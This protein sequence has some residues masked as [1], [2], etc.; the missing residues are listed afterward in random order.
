MDERQCLLLEQVKAM[1][2]EMQAN[3][4]R[5]GAEFDAI[6]KDMLQESGHHQPWIEKALGPRTRPLW[7]RSNG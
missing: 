3:N 4:V 6:L 1:L 7:T 2:D 5:P